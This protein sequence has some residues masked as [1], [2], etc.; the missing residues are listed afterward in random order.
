MYTVETK[1]KQP[2][3]IAFPLHHVKKHALC[4]R[5]NRS[6]DNKFIMIVVDIGLP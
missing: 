4:V 6:I 1:K 3:N 5:I 2:Q